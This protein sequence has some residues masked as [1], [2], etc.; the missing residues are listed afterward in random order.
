MP[1]QKDK[2]SGEANNE[3]SKDEEE[4]TKEA[5]KEVAATSVHTA[6]PLFK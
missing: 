6:E 4:E 1:P 2:H 3:D 5:L